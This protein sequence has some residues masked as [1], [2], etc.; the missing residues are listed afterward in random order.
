MN[1]VFFNDAIV[2]CLVI[3]GPVTQKWVYTGSFL[4][5]VEGT[6]YEF[7]M[8]DYGTHKPVGIYRR[9]YYDQN[10]K[11]FTVVEQLLNMVAKL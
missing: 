4:D 1:D 10:S 11:S 7:E 2:K 9:G 8:V 3:R 5:T 6:L